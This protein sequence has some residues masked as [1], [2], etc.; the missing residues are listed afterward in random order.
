MPVI[1]N[2]FYI[3]TTW[4]IPF[5]YYTFYYAG[6]GPYHED[7]NVINLY[8]DLTAA[9]HF[10][11]YGAAIELYGKITFDFIFGNVATPDYIF[12][13]EGEADIFTIVPYKQILFFTRIQDVVSQG[14]AFHGWMGGAY[15]VDVGSAFM[16]YCESSY[17]GSSDLWT[18]T[19]WTNDPAGS[20]SP[21]YQSC[22]DDPTLTVSLMQFVPNNYQQYIGEV[23]LYQ[24][25]I[26]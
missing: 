14:T 5:D 11:E 1:T 2:G 3:T 24:Q 23:E 18:G 21:S 12:T 16:S 17:T 4:D 20:V 26:F 10:E 22:W 13:V 25:P 7:I 8:S 6:V 15:S 19:Y 9:Q